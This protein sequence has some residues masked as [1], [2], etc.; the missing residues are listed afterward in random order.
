MFKRIAIAVDPR[1]ATAT[2]VEQ[3]AEL[4]SQLGAAVALIHVVD[5]SLGTVPEA[6]VPPADLLADFEESG[7]DYLA[8]VRQRL[9]ADLEVEPF[10]REGKPVDEILAVADEW[11]ADL[12]VVGL[13]HHS[14]LAQ[15][16][17]PSTTEAVV[18][19][20]SCPVLVIP[21]EASE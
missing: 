14:G 18:R 20:S 10:L 7:E 6:G 1:E 21:P 3:G 5:P 13:Q 2:A 15:L 12:I 11:R 9:P 4:A 19:H 8:S 17:L 16:L